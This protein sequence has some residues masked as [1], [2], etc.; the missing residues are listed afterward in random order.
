LGGIGTCTTS[1]G[2]PPGCGV[3]YKLAPPMA[4]GGAWT[5]TVLHSFTGEDGAQ[6]SAALI[7][8]CRGEFFGTTAYGGRG[9]DG[10]ASSGYGSV[11]KLMETHSRLAPFPSPETCR[12]SAASIEE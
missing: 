1:N 10:S 3:L 7:F 12:R 2:F 4:P 5:E 11:F 9:Y 8:G 6:P